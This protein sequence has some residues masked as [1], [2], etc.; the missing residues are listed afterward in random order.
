MDRGWTRRE[1]KRTSRYM[2]HR[3]TRLR[4]TVFFVFFLFLFFVL[5]VLCFNWKALGAY[6]SQLE[7]NSKRRLA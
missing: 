6:V 2:I 7:I 5:F 3:V 1:R 4:F